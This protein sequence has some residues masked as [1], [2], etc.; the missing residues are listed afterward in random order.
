MTLPVTSDILVPLRNDRCDSPF[1]DFLKQSNLVDQY[2]ILDSLKEF[3][4]K[5]NDFANN[6]FLAGKFMHHVSSLIRSGPSNPGYLEARKIIMAVRRVSNAM[7]KINK[8]QARGGYIPE[9]NLADDS[10]DPQ[11]VPSSRVGYFKEGLVDMVVDITCRSRVYD[12]GAGHGR[13]LHY[14]VKLQK[15]QFVSE[16]SYV[17]HSNLKALKFR[18]SLDGLAYPKSQVFSYV[19]DMNLYY[20]DLPR[21]PTDVH[22]FLNSIYN[23]DIDLIGLPNQAGIVMLAGNLIDE[24]GAPQEVVSESFHMVYE[25]GDTVSGIVD[26]Y[27]FNERMMCS[28]DFSHTGLYPLK[29]ICPRKIKDI[30]DPFW[31]SYA[32]FGE[33]FRVG[34]Q[35]IK[36]KVGRP[37][38]LVQCGDVPQKLRR[39]SVHR[40]TYHDYQWYMQVGCYVSAKLHGVAAFVFYNQTINSYRVTMRNGVVY[41]PFYDDGVNEPF[42][43]GD[44]G[45]FKGK[46]IFIELLVMDV[47]DGE[48]LY[49]YF[50]DYVPNG[51]PT[52]QEKLIP[53]YVK[54]YTARLHHPQLSF[55]DYYPAQNGHLSLITPAPSDGLVITDPFGNYSSYWKGIE[56]YDVEINFVA[57]KW[58]VENH[59]FTISDPFSKLK[60]PGIYECEL[61]DASL[62]V[63]HYRPDK[64]SVSKFEMEEIEVL[65][66]NHEE[67]FLVTRF[68]EMTIDVCRV[69]DSREDFHAPYTK[70]MGI[71]FKAAMSDDHS[72]YLARAFLTKIQGDVSKGEE[73][74]I[75]VSSFVHVVSMIA[76]GKHPIYVWNALHAVGFAVNSPDDPCVGVGGPLFKYR[77]DYAGAVYHRITVQDAYVADRLTKCVKAEGVSVGDFVVIG[78]PYG[79][80]VKRIVREEGNHHVLG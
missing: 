69:Y 14:I 42:N 15:G 50:I 32:F 59:D 40:L 11:E 44:I 6:N 12:I 54:N 9:V 43:F 55:K 8:K 1:L 79:D 3:G 52:W 74:V 45:G 63:C 7:V 48:K 41:Q 29:F 71:V 47:G 22:L 23:L 2:L 24:Y 49:P 35:R 30:N 10:P 53:L 60:V 20:R 75:P 37:I 34:L 57:G 51:N 5:T 72:M 76:P 38:R 78:T 25:G 28:T 80:K 33:K 36:G 27:Q 65:E 66:F 39:P 68:G 18:D 26:G 56:T 21:K 13:A 46:H 17:D 31:G 73:L 64:F 70:A 4:I 77:G 67:G 16:Y 61:I 19:T 62:V 58:V